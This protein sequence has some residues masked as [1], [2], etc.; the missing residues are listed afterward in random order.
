MENLHCMSRTKLLKY[1]KH[2]H[3]E[4]S[5]KHGRPTDDLIADVAREEYSERSLKSVG[6]LET[7]PNVICPAF[8]L[9]KPSDQKAYNN[10]RKFADNLYFTTIGN[11]SFTE[12]NDAGADDTSKPQRYQS[13]ET[14]RLPRTKRDNPF[15]F[16][17][18]KTIDKCGKSF[19]PLLSIDEMRILKSDPMLKLQHLHGDNS[20]VADAK[21]DYRKYLKVLSVIVALEDNTTLDIMIEK[22]LTTV[23]IPKGSMIIFDSAIGHSGS[24]NDSKF[25]NT[26]VHCNLKSEDVDIV[27]NTVVEYYPCKFK[28]GYYSPSRNQQRGHH[29]NC[30]L[31]PKYKHRREIVKRSDK[32]YRMKKKLKKNF[33]RKNSN[34]KN[35]LEVSYIDDVSINEKKA[36]K[37]LRSNI[38]SHDLTPSADFEDGK[39]L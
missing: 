31:G 17:L 35:V 11:D 33:H 16:D 4:I 6:L 14:M 32:K 34:G 19:N 28:C 20:L 5:V 18:I 8:N 26:R 12:H 3:P 30:R 9:R 38:Q 23:G 15:L 24:P 13:I 39:A 2:K 36:I 10:F 1:I 22:H 37:T 21:S 7:F 29:C 25:E 27:K